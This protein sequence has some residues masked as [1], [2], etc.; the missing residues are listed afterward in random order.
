MVFKR[1]SAYDDQVGDFSGFDGPEIPFYPQTGRSVDGGH[2]DGVRS[3]ETSLISSV[4]QEKMQ[5]AENLSSYPSVM[6]FFLLISLGN[7]IGVSDRY[8][9]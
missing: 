3:A 5:Q 9:S 1:I 8:C 7:S 2:P 6:E 4:I